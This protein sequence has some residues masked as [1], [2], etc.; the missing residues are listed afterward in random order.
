MTN[1]DRGVY[2]ECLRANELVS[3]QLLMA[4]FRVKDLRT[5]KQFLASISVTGVKV[6]RSRYYYTSDI[7]DGFAILQK[8]ASEAPEEI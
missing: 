3:E 2:S 6:G 7:I 8:A 4:K 5:V 1:E